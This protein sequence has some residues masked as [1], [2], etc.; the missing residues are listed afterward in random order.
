MR[1]LLLCM[2]LF[3]CISVSAQKKDKIKGD[4]NVTLEERTFDYF[5]KIE[6]NDKIKVTLK[7]DNAVRLDIEADENLHDVIESELQNG[8]L[9]LSLNK[10]IV[11]S[12]RFNLTL[13]VDDLDYIELNDDS[14]I[15][16]EDKFDFFD[17]NVVLNDKSDIKIYIDSKTFSTVSNEKSKGNFTVK[18]DSI[19]IDLKESSK[20]KYA[21]NT[22]KLYVGYSG[23]ATGEFVGK[24]KELVLNANDNATYKGYE[25]LAQDA[26]VDASN[27]SNSYVNSKS[28]LEITAKDKSKVYIFNSPSIV[29]KSFEDTASLLKRESMRLLEKL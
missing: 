29:I 27:N 17:I 16:G 9:I 15:K 4:K 23:S 13:Y 14:E 19:S 1:I 21:L 24:T 18:A 7:Q 28:N 12:K 22:E 11:S 25:L 20:I 8:V 6:V 2:S 10:R 5:S 26:L 3:L